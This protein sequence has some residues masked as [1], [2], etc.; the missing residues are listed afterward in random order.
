MLGHTLLFLLIPSPIISEI[1]L[2]NSYN[3]TSLFDTDSQLDLVQIA[4]AYT[5]YSQF[6]QVILQSQQAG[7]THFISMADWAG[8]RYEL[9]I[10]DVLALDVFVYSKTEEPVGVMVVDNTRPEVL[11]ASELRAVEV[12]VVEA[13]FGNCRENMTLSLMNMQLLVTS[14]FLQQDSR[15][16]RNQ[17]LGVVEEEERVV[18]YGNASIE[19][20]GWAGISGTAPDLCGDINATVEIEVKCPQG[21]ELILSNALAEGD[22]VRYGFFQRTPTEQVNTT[23]LWYRTGANNKFNYS[24][25]NPSLPP[26]TPELN[27][28]CS[29]NNCENV[30]YWNVT[31]KGCPIVV[32]FNRSASVVNTTWRLYIGMTKA[33]KQ[34]FNSFTYNVS[35]MV[36]IEELYARS[37]FSYEYRLDEN[38][39]GYTLLSFTDE[40]FY[41]FRFNLTSSQH[42]TLCDYTTVSGEVEI[43]VLEAPTISETRFKQLY[44]DTLLPPTTP[45]DL[46]V[47]YVTVVSTV[48][49]LFLFI[50]LYFFQIYLATKRLNLWKLRIR[51]DLGLT[52][53]DAR[54]RA[55]EV[56]NAEQ[57]YSYNILNSR[58]RARAVKFLREWLNIPDNLVPAFEDGEEEML[59]KHGIDF[60]KNALPGVH[61]LDN[62]IAKLIRLVTSNYRA[63]VNNDNMKFI[64]QQY[65]DLRDVGR[66]MSENK[67]GTKF[68]S[69][70]WSPVNPVKTQRP[71]ETSQTL[72][73]DHL[74]R[75]NTLFGFTSTRTS[76][77]LETTSPG[78]SVSRE[79]KRSEK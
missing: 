46:T 55:M 24:N 22:C 53:L 49:G 6:P 54:I 74:S 29:A 70:V 64:S 42:A 19:V 18:E 30:L 51:R 77:R 36:V 31:E 63:R 71:S 14:L 21:R 68:R 34:Q 33:D 38:N 72:G 79:F 40:G 17:S 48:A 9:D 11:A 57:N 50:S 32:Y 62:P 13:G 65:D 3:S 25:L 66:S 4:P 7:C 28:I 8:K 15:A 1:I 73:L 12:G 56:H 41:H 67:L 35:E 78:F 59:V 52:D 76:E 47:V 44:N 45:P 23:R 60:A 39:N 5:K 20:S 75:R 27:G 2:S 69:T 58:E 61:I 37:S 26:N 10:L 16:L 43:F